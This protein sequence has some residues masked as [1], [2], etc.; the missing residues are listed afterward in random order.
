M[1]PCGIGQAPI[2]MSDERSLEFGW[3]TED[4][5]RIHA[6]GWL[7][8]NRPRSVICLLHGL[9]EHSGRYESFAVPLTGAQHAVLTFDLRGHGRSEGRRGHAPGFEALHRDIDHLLDEAAERFDDIPRFLY[10]QSMGGTLALTHA[11]R[12]S[13]PYCGIIASSPNIRPAL[14]VP[15][16]KRFLGGLLYST[17]P[18]FS[19]SNGIRHQDLSGD[20]NVGETYERDPLKHDRVSARLGIDLLR[21]G[22]RALQNASRFPVPLLLLHGTED[23]I[24]SSQATREFAREAGGSCTLRMLETTSHELHNDPNSEHLFNS[25]LEWIDRLIPSAERIP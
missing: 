10:G 20:P 4:R 6:R 12:R 5:L 17:W 24:T 15:P 11:L 21:N 22:V 2:G 16:W 7:P 9:G 3:I 25:I 23:R 14:A 19:M 18:T 1:H 13:T 8:A